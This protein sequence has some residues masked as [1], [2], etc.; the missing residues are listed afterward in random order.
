MKSVHVL[1]CFKL[2]VFQIYGIQDRHW[3]LYIMNYVQS[4]H[5][6]HGS[7]SKEWTRTIQV[8]HTVDRNFS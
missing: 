7:F 3:Y 6:H 8:K 4:T 1:R 5:H 2:Q